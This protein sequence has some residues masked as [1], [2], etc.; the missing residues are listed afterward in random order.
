M[1]R[2]E[3]PIGRGPGGRKI[4]APN[5]F[6]QALLLTSVTDVT[7]LV[8]AQAQDNEMTPPRCSFHCALDD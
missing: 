2:A 7:I 3:G 8:A 4:V 1:S 5:W 6:P